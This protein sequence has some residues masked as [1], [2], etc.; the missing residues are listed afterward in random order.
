MFVVRIFKQE[1]AI[2]KMFD[3]STMKILEHLQVLIETLN[4]SKLIQDVRI[5][6]PHHLK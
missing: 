5:I 6:K 3:L 2:Q 4:N 1:S